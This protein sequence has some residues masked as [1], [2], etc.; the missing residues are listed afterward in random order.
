MQRSPLRD[1]L[2]SGTYLYARVSRAILEN[3]F[4]PNTPLHDGATVISGDT[5]L[6]SGCFLPLTSS[7][8]L[9][10]DLGTRHRAALGMSETS[11]AMV[12][13][14]SEETGV[15]SIAEKGALERFVDA[16]QL[17]AR[18]SALY[19]EKMEKPASRKGFRFRRKR[20]E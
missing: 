7:N 19:E 17:K 5:I 3:I 18:L 2:E 13:V 20:H 1:I 6:A 4:V 10:K 9:S 14:V 15:V 11:D 8:E 16:N 12:I